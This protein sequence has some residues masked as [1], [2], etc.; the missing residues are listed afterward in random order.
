[1]AKF[2]DHTGAEWGLRLTVGS[3]ADVK[4]ETGVNLALVSKDTSWVDAIFGDPAKLV[5]ILYVLCG[6]QCKAAGVSPEEFG[7]RFDGPT[8]EAAGDSLAQAIADFFPRSAVARAVGAGLT[9]LL[10]AM[11][12]KA[13][14]EI[15]RRISTACSSPSSAPESP[16]SIPPP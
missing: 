3:V 9:K 2:T 10:T 4:R 13:V 16:G 15:E 11:D 6:D 5:E 8:L 12:A 7:H 14:A 1:M